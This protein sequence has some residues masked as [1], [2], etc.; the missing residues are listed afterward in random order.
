MRFAGEPQTTHFGVGGGTALHGG[1][2]PRK[3]VPYLDAQLSLYWFGFA[4]LIVSYL[5]GACPRKN[6]F[7]PIP[8]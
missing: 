4:G 3:W 2:E 5:K 7:D 8:L 6:F 1:I